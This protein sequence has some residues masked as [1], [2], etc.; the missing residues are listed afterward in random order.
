MGWEMIR[1]N[2]QIGMALLLA[3]STAGCITTL[4]MSEEREW[5]RLL[6][7]QVVQEPIP[8]KSPAVTGF[9]SFVV[10]GVGHFYVGES[11]LGVAYFLG[12]L[13]WP[14]NPF[15]TLPAGL[16]ACTVINKRRTIEYY[17]YG[18]HQRTIEKLR[19]KDKLPPNF[20]GVEEAGLR[21]T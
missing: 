7:R 5:G 2:A 1:R 12:N 14:L 9:W 17:K 20:K 6:E 4:A 11:G 10:P 15:W 21:E 8:F 19:K 13:L 16:Q 18:A 3:V